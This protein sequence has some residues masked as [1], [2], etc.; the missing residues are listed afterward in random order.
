MEKPPKS[1]APRYLVDKYKEQAE[2]LLKQYGKDFDRFT[3]N[4]GHLIEEGDSL[5]LNEKVTA[6]NIL[7]SKKDMDLA[8]EELLIFYNNYIGMPE[9]FGELIAEMINEEIIS[10]DQVRLGKKASKTKFT[11][12]WKPDPEHEKLDWVEGKDETGKIQKKRVSKTVE[13]VLIFTPKDDDQANLIADKLDEKVGWVFPDI[14]ATI[15][16]RDALSK[17]GFQEVVAN[18]RGLDKTQL[19]ALHEFQKFDRPY[20]PESIMANPDL[21]TFIATSKFPFG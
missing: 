11:G 19:I 20:T 8:S 7:L 5:I 15:S 17:Q 1:E 14:R 13:T 2:T 6:Y 4:L 9:H 18:I 12:K 16:L 3:E 10:E 21:V